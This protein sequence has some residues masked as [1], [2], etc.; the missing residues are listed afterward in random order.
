MS[1]CVSIA[2]VFQ[3]HRL[4]SSGAGRARAAPYAGAVAGSTTST[5]AELLDDELAFDATTG[6]RLSNHLPM[7]L[8][9]LERLGADDARLTEFAQRYRSRLVPVEDAEPVSGLGEWRA[10]RGAAH[11]YAPVRSYLER[12]IAVDGRDAV[13]RRHLA[14]LVDGLS[15][16]AFHGIIRLAYALES[17]SDARV[18]AGLAYLTQVHQLLGARGRGAV[19]TDDPVVALDRVADLDSL[20]DAAATGN[21]GQRMRAVAAHPAFDGV[22]DWLAVDEATPAR[23][24]DAATALYAQSDDFVA[25][26]GLTG[27]HAISIVAPYVEDRAALSAYWFQALAAAYAT[28]GAPR[29]TDPTEAVAGWIAAP[30][31]WDEIARRAAQSDDEHVSKLVYTARTLDERAPNPLLRAA[32][33][34]QARVA[35]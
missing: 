34:R 22:I 7:A 9:A 10:A 6:T 8:V 25:L 30:T 32:A 2:A 27:S 31:P 11:A 15:G 5:L 13:V 3:R 28:I 35:P 21:I 1:F 18:A 33:A 12:C 24:T 14:E 23:L 17:A 4:L 20:R 29:L 19:I 26:H 16:A